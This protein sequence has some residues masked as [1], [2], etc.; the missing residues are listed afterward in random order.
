MK[1]VRIR[2]SAEACSH[3]CVVGNNLNVSWESK[4]MKKN[5]TYIVGRRKLAYRMKPKHVAV[6]VMF[7]FN[8]L[9]R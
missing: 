1:E 7:N 9:L 6:F 2:F 5:R 3:V 4:R 8:K